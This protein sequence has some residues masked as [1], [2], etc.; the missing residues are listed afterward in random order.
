[1]LLLSVVL[2]VVVCCLCCSVVHHVADV[3]VWCIMLFI[4]YV[5]AV[6]HLVVHVVVLCSKQK[7]TYDVTKLSLCMI[8]S[9][10]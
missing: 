9:T 6:M 1:M 8:L 7:N 5:H 10:L 2:Y 4:L 3:V